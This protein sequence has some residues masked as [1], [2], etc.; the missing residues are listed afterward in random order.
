V[1]SDET[2]FRGELARG[3]AIQDGLLASAKPRING[4]DRTDSCMAR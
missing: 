4:E 3:L 2:E 1:D